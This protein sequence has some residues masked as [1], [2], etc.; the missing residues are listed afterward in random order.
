MIADMFTFYFL[1]LAVVGAVILYAVILFWGFENFPKIT[2]VITA[3]ILTA[4]IFFLAGKAI[5]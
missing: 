3:I 4:V 1:G 2:T 5:A